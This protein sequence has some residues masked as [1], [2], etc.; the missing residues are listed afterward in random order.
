MI[1]SNFDPL[2]L[3]SVMEVPAAYPRIVSEGNTDGQWVTPNA[4]KGW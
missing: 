2:S 1:L 4:I 3:K